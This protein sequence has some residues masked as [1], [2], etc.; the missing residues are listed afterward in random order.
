MFAD[1]MCENSV[2]LDTGKQRKNDEGITCIV[3]NFNTFKN[4]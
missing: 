3:K 2:A 4:N 1:H